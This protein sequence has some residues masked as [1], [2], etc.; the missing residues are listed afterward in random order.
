MAGFA[1]FL[2][3]PPNNPL[4]ATIATSAPNT[5]CHSGM[6]TGRL[7]ASNTPLTAAERSE[8]V[9][10]LPQSFSK[11]HSKNMQAAAHT[12]VTNSARHPKLITPATSA[13]ASAMSTSRMML[14]VVIFP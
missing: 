6:D 5:A 14:C 11:P 9:L 4:T 7:Y 12:A 8:M 13:G 3:R 10:G 2:P 1:K